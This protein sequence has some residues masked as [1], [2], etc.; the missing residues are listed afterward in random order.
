MNIRFLSLLILF[1]LFYSCDKNEKLFYRFSPNESSIYFKNQLVEN[2]KFNLIEY[3]YFYNGGGVATG[4]I[5]ND[6]LLDVYF[7]SNQGE[8]KLYLNK[9]NFKF[10]DI[11]KIAGVE[12]LGEWKTGVSMVDLNGDGYL[13]I[14]QTRLGGYKN[15]IGKNELF[16]N[17]GDLTFT[18]SAKEYGLD[19]EGFSTHSAFFDYDSDGDLDVYLLNHSVHTERSYGSS[20]LR[21][22]RN[23]K[24]G[25]KLYRNEISD[26]KN[27]FTDVSEESGIL[28]SN[29]GYGLGISISDI[30][31]DGCDDIY[32]SNDFREND[33]LYINNCDGTFKENLEKNIN[34]TSRFSMGNDISDIN[35]DL[36]P[37]IFVLDMLPEDEK[38]LKSSSGDDSY[39]IYKLKL[40]FGFNKQFAR[41][42]LQ[43]NNGNNSFSEVSQ[44][45]GIHATDWSW[46]TLM[47]DFD[48]DGNIDLYISNG[49]V[50]RPN[51]M[52]YIN[53]LSNEKI[54]SGLVQNPDLNNKDLLNEMPDGKVSNYAFK[55]LSDLEFKNVSKDWG[56]D[57]EGYSNGATY[58]DFDKDGDQDLVVN[59]IND[60]SFIYK[61]NSRE[62]NLGNYLN[63]EFHGKN[64]NLNGIGAKVTLWSDQKII[65]KE[66]FLNRGFMSSKSSGLNFG[67]GKSSMIDSLEVVWSSKKSQ[68]LYS[69]DVNKTIELFEE[70]ANEIFKNNN[71]NP[72]I[73]H[74]LSNEDLIE[75]KHN[76]NVFNDFNRESLIPYMISKEGPAIAVADINNDEFQ[77]IY[78]G[79]P[80]F[81][82]SKLFFG[83]KSGKYKLSQQISIEKDY[84]SEDVDALFFDA[85]NDGDLDLYVISAGNEFSVNS[86]SV[87]DRMYFNNAGVYEKNKELVEI[88]QHNSVVKNY[89]Y[90]NDGD[91][92]LF[93]GG[94]VIPSEYGISPKSY[95]LKNDGTG[96]FK[97]DI[98]FKDLGMITDAKWSDMNG[99]GIKD[100]ITCGDWN[101]I[102]VFINKNGELVMDSLFIGR[103]LKG[104]WFSIETADLNNDGKMDIIAG[105]LGNNS[106][107]KPSKEAEVHMYID[108]FDNNS[109]LE[110]IITYQKKSKEYPI[111]NKDE[112]SKQLNY[113]NRDFFYYKDFAGL[114]IREIFSEKSLSNSK[115]LSVNNFNSM[116]LLNYGKNFEAI[117]LPLLAQV[118][119]IRDIQ[120]LDYNKDGNKDL[121]LVGNNSNVSPFF[122]S[123]DSNFG[124]LLKGEGNGNFSYI[125]QSISGLKIRGDVSKILPLDKN[126]SKF[127][128]GKNDDNISIISLANEK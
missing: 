123:F 23:E 19:F 89:D 61:N 87:K 75:Y 26:G 95:L 43:L 92:D 106:K 15:I 5:N 114:D 101:S 37:D 54:N 88:N 51:D 20:K 82:E 79:S 39:E 32:I 128:I 48:I 104:W 41:N 122:G 55:N 98:I 57:Y 120:V 25:D 50:K 63:I 6:G 64:F 3:L 127:V 76:E 8:N 11:S 38:V 46:S 83:N 107:L 103:S 115:K 42:T 16:I 30:N 65:Y 59:N 74:D 67:L 10:E 49:I 80:S 91:Q 13:D 96:N 94:R 22:E 118:S 31:R 58:D 28:G 111:A 97:I 40:G 113:L 84:L 33:Y 4:D 53:F 47:E 78:I 17:N 100:L 126:K 52:D 81:Q 86:N 14:Y 2:E 34:Y 45:L 66:N 102:N 36:Y 1:A 29:I 73:F 109:R 9:G 121:L 62:K 105:N 112:L 68:K 116:V 18:E 125:N 69:I 124:V 108:D 21:Y 119:P 44:L 93:I 35:N 70:N 56:L 85:D 72:I 110:H 71:D 12:S 77:D 60:Y 90:D 7:V 99:D 27:I 24:S 117:E